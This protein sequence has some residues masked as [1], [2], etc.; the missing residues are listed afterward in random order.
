[1]QGSW[2]SGRDSGPSAQQLD[3]LGLP[4]SSGFLTAAEGAV[5]GAWQEAGVNKVQPWS[6]IQPGQYSSQ[7]PQ[8][9]LETAGVALGQA[10]SS[11]VTAHELQQDLGMGEPCLAAFPHQ[12]ALRAPTP[13]N[14]PLTWT[15][16]SG[17]THT[18]PKHSAMICFMADCVF[19]TSLSAAPSFHPLLGHPREP[20]TWPQHGPRQLSSFLL[21]PPRP[22]AAPEVLG[23]SLCYK[24]H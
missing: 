9:V 1:M 23:G 21:S 15:T 24:T 18:P 11:P 8:E 12:A 7:A 6:R 13:A 3:L 10:P 22:K 16:G 20:H 17:P 19:P 14:A 5:A 2:R 4:D